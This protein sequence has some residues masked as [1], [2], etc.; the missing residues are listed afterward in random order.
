MLALTNQIN[1][2]NAIDA[3]HAASRTSEKYGFVSTRSVIDNLTSLGFTTRSVQIQRVNKEER[4]GFQKHI[5][6]MQHQS[7][8]PKVGDEF[9]EVVLINSH[10]GGCSYRMM[11]GM[12]RLVCTNGMVSGN[13]QDEI[14]FV[15]RKINIDRINE[16]VM[17]IVN[18]AE[19]LGDVVSRMKSRELTLPEQASFVEEAVKLRYNAPE[20]G[21][22]LEDVHE[23]NNRRNSIN[24]IRRYED[25]GNNLWLTFN[26]VQENL[27]QG[28]RRGSGVRRITSPSTDLNVN[29]ELWNL[30]EQFLN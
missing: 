1:Q 30:A 17:Q 23:W 19:R 6:R 27:T 10:D 18:R 11:L 12:F 3:I 15:H 20:N 9:P 22:P 14:R 7:L 21:A 8:M 29:R 5:V 4:K 13:I 28:G 25:R 16:G 26:R 2:L 24:A